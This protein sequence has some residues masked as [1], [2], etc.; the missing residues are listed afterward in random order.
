[1]PQSLQ[2]PSTTPVYSVA[3]APHPA[4][5]YASYVQAPYI[6]AAYHGYGNVY[7][8]QNSSH[9]VYSPASNGIPINVSHGIVRQDATGVFI[10][11]LNHSVT[12]AELRRILKKIAEPIECRIHSRPGG[13]RPGGSATARFAIAEEASRVVDRLHH[14]SHRERTLNVRLDRETTSRGEASAPAIVNGSTA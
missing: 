13:S 8:Y 7:S 2:L 14:R 9:P 5:T 11:N 6:Q 10:S 1:M 3:P 12:E 4:I